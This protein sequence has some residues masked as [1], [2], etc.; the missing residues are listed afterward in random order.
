MCR[1]RYKRE[2]EQQDFDEDK[3][4]QLENI[5]NSKDKNIII[6]QRAK[7]PLFLREKAKEFI[8]DIVKEGNEGGI[9]EFVRDKLI[10]NENG[11]KSVNMELYK[12]LES[13]FLYKMFVKTKII[14]N[15]KIKVDEKKQKLIIL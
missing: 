3:I 13:F 8:R 11:N 10:I 9:N 14:D 6:D 15:D 1:S 7:F 5:L 12:N 4:K 2:L